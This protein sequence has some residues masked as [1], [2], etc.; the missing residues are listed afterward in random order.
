M[1]HSLILSM[2]RKGSTGDEILQILNTLTDGLV[3]ETN[4]EDFNSDS[5]DSDAVDS[6]V[7]E[8]EP[9]AELAAV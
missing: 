7:E 1:S 8:Y 6:E 3:S 9:D 2:L 5:V 4:Q